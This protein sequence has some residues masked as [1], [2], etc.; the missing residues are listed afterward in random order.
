MRLPGT[1]VRG[2]RGLSKL[3]L[4]AIKN[5]APLGPH[6]ATWG[7]FHFGAALQKALE[8]AGASVV[9]HYWPDWDKSD[10]EDAIVVLRGKRAFSPRKGPFAVIWVVSHPATVT[11]PEL[12]AYDL[13]YVGSSTHFNMI[14]DAVKS[15]VK[16]LRQCSDD[17]IFNAGSAA[18]EARSGTIF[19]ANSRGVLRNALRWALEAGVEPTV[20]GTQ[21]RLLGLRHL[22]ERLHIDN[23]ELPD[24]YRRS[25]LS[26]NDHWTDMI[27]F[28]YINNRIF[29]CIF[30]GLPVLSD[31]FPELREVC[32]DGILYAH[33]TASFREAYRYSDRE[34][35]R[36]VE[37]N[38]RA[39]G[40]AAR[41]VHLLGEGGGDCRRHHARF[42]GFVRPPVRAPW[43]PSA[44]TSPSGEPQGRDLGGTVLDEVLHFFG[45]GSDRIELLHICPDDRAL[46][47][48]ETAP[49]FS[50]LSAGLGIGPWQVGLNRELS[51]VNKRRFDA[52]VVDSFKDD[53][54]MAG[55]ERRDFLLRLAARLRRG[56]L[57]AL[58]KDVAA[59]A[60]IPAAG[61]KLLKPGRTDDRYL[62][63][64]TPQDPA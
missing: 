57:F 12:E 44:S 43:P 41:P 42:G 37:E 23:D 56:G 64:S 25:R 1:I 38:L 16:I 40:E 47:S 24:F 58:S 46:N 54:G 8:R 26:L 63:F 48:R 21:W 27:Y 19:V 33:D 49:R 61:T 20:I 53:G 45:D 32:G 59:S 2:R 9:Q 60:D 7:D 17:S 34:L 55:A 10:G 14:K 50:Y 28:G 31:E 22:V 5:P 13:A 18:N 15:E 29:D 51:Q 62:Y 4:I 6:Q 52:I 30:C 3:M 36:A 35:P 11:V 39:G